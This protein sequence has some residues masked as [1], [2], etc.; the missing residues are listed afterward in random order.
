[1]STDPFDPPAAAPELDADPPRVSVLVY[2]AAIA[3][4][5]TGVV[6]CATSL[7]QMIFVHWR[8]WVW[9]LP[10]LI[11]LLGMG[12]IL[13][14]AYLS[15]GSAPAAFLGLGLSA[16]MGLFSLVWLI[17]TLWSGIFSLLVL[18]W[19]LSCAPP[20]LLVTFSLPSAMAVTRYKRALRT[21]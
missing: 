12:Q 8:S 16:V 10:P 1:M 4:M 6:A 15:R 7:Q 2:L 21:L 3:L 20:V 9:V 14:S 11:G 17:T 5:I 19:F 18:L 13:A